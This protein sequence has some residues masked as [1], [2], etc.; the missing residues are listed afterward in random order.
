MVLSL[1][2]VCKRKCTTA[3]QGGGKALFH[4][5]VAFPKDRGKNT[6]GYQ[7]R[8][9][10]VL[11]QQIPKIWGQWRVSGTHHLYGDLRFNSDVDLPL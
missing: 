7:R 2:V 1:A 6:D 8:G 4:A 11:K 3:I 10:S 5:V 9:Y